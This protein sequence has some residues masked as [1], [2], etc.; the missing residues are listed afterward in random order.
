MRFITILIIAFC[1][2]SCT[3]AQDIPVKQKSAEGEVTVEA[4][5]KKE[6][7]EIRKSLKGDVK[8]KLK[9]DGKGLYTWEISGK[10]AQEV[11]KAN[12]TLRKRLGEAQ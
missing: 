11:L 10:D 3:R 7:E 6:M 1:L 4:Q 8:I 2:L 9:K 12:D 5:H